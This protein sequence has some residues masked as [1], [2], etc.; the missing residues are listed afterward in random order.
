[1]AW[2]FQ[3]APLRLPLRRMGEMFHAVIREGMGM[4]GFLVKTDAKAL[5]RVG[6]VIPPPQLR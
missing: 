6:I 3:A 4:A 2:L 5:P 1:M